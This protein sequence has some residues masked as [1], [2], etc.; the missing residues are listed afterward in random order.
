LKSVLFQIK[1]VYFHQKN[2]KE[3]TKLKVWQIAS[4]VWTRPAHR[5]LYSFG[6]PNLFTGPPTIR[7]CAWQ[8]NVYLLIAGDNTSDNIYKGQFVRTIWS[9]MD[10]LVWKF[11]HPLSAKS[12]Y[13]SRD[14]DGQ[15]V[16]FVPYVINNNKRLATFYSSVATPS[17]FGTWLRIGLV[18][19]TLILILE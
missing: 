14:A 15:M 7:W 2:L 10:H 8:P 11:G 9:N 18:L 17:A 3:K 6:L 1:I 12:S 13:G 4:D 5:L 19:S 16:A